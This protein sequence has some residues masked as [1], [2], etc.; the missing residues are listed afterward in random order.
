[1]KINFKNK[2]LK[3]IKSARREIISMG[4]KGIKTYFLI[5]IFRL[6]Y[7]LVHFFFPFFFLYSEFFK[8][9]TPLPPP[10]QKK[11]EENKETIRK[12]LQLLRKISFFRFSHI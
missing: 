8:I 11:K 5:D 10:H 2:L 7:L 12:M 1:M 4:I 9:L 3:F 6:K